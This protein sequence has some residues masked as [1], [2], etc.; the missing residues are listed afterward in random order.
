MKENVKLALAQISSRREN[1]KE[2][3]Q[4]IEKY[5]LKAKEREADVVIFPELSMTGYVVHDQIYELA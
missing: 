3:L 4:K 5:T 1:K 2:N